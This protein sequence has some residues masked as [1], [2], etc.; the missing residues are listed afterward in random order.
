MQKFWGVITAR[1][2]A[3]ISDQ[4]GSLFDYYVFHKKTSARQYISMNV[5]KKYLQLDFFSLS[6]P[7]SASSFASTCGNLHRK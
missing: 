6:F 5:V 7:L 1:K 3:I 2:C 4:F